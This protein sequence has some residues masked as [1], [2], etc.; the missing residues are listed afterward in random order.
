MV[1]FK[2]THK[3]TQHPPKIRHTRKKIHISK[4]S[5]PSLITTDI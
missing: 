2:I 5:M 4:R 1:I 3:I